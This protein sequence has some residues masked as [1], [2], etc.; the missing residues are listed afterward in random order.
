MLL[1]CM[2][3]ACAWVPTAARKIS[4]MPVSFSFVWTWPPAA[5]GRCVSDLLVCPGTDYLFLFCMFAKYCSSVPDPGTAAMCSSPAQALPLSCVDRIEA[6]RVHQP[7]R[8]SE[9]PWSALMSWC[10]CLRGLE[11]LTNTNTSLDASCM[12]HSTRPG[13]TA[14]HLTNGLAMSHSCESRQ[15][16]N[17][18]HVTSGDAQ[19]SRSRCHGC[20]MGTNHLLRTV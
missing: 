3:G 11:S 10:P 20:Y 18:D 17:T 5:T 2:D 12:G 8:L 6:R 9:M 16:S 13:S 1:H 19:P 15:V 4:F 7:L 14:C